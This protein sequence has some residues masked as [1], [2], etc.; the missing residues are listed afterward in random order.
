MLI[1][2]YSD[3]GRYTCFPCD[4][5]ICSDCAAKEVFCLFSD[6]VFSDC[7]SDCVFLDFVFRLCFDWKNGGGIEYDPIQ[8]ANSH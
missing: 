3:A 6:C 8:I 2:Q 5:D 1:V 7:I 4:I